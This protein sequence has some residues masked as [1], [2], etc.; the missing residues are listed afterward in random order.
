MD[1][2]VLGP[3]GCVPDPNVNATTHG[4]SYPTELAIELTLTHKL[5]LFIEFVNETAECKHPRFSDLSEK[6]LSEFLS[7]LTRL[8][9]ID[10]ARLIKMQIIVWELSRKTVTSANDDIKDNN[11]DWKCPNDDWKCAEYIFYF[12]NMI[13]K[14]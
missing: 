14:R 3:N 11:D 5:C 1:G 13:L 6:F 8:L 4:Y 2:F 9:Q 12:R 10:R 7:A